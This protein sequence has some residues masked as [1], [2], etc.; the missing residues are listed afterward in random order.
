[1]LASNSNKLGISPEEFQSI[2]EIGAMFYEQGNL[3]K[4]RIIFE[5]LIEA[6]SQ[7]GAAHSALG[8]LLT[9]QNEPDSALKHLDKAIELDEKQIAPFVNRA[10][11]HLRKQDL[12]AA[13]AD[14]KRAI[15]L[16]PK[17]KDPG[18][19]RARAM[20]LGIYQEIE[21]QRARKSKNN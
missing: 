4:A 11:I 12:E 2:G 3:E 20:V 17:E 1:M 5:G 13:V 19:N 16:D 15:E 8:A 18:A 9:R 6:D 10:E 7:S 14:L 21:A